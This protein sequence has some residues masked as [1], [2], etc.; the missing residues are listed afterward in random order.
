MGIICPTIFS[1]S[2]FII[3]LGAIAVCALIQIETKFRVGSWPEG[4]LIIN[5]NTKV[6]VNLG[7]SN[8]G[9]KVFSDCIIEDNKNCS[10]V[11]IFPYGNKFLYKPDVKII[12]EAVDSLISQD[13]VQMNW[14]P[15]FDCSEI[16]ECVVKVHPIEVWV[17]LLIFCVIAIIF[18]I[19]CV[20]LCCLCSAT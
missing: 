8:P 13:K 15:N 1:I 16:I 20:A 9:S 6:E 5:N 7:D 17:G 3:A 19:L 11:A 12:S 4:T 2:I 10:C 14:D 18:L